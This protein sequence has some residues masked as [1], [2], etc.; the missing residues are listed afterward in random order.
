VIAHRSCPSLVSRLCSCLLS[1]V[2]CINRFACPMNARRPAAWVMYA[3]WYQGIAYRPAVRRKCRAG[4]P[5]PNPGAGSLNVEYADKV[6]GGRGESGIFRNFAKTRM[7]PSRSNKR[8]SSLLHRFSS[9]RYLS[10]SMPP[11]QTQRIRTTRACD[12]RDSKTWS[13]PTALTSVAM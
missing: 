8:L 4:V 1:D 10:R 2:S 11:D 3:E 6:H 13:R 7:N 5:T 12:V 9:F